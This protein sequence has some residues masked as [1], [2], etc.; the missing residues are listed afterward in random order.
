METR[1]ES[2]TVV[3]VTQDEVLRALGLDAA[4]AD[5]AVSM[6]LAHCGRKLVI[7]IERELAVQDA[8]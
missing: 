5:G 7:T 1:H 4:A 6:E 2:R 3:R 8:D